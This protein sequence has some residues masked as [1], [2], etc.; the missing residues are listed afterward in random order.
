MIR[1]ILTIIGIAAMALVVA[2]M[3]VEA[4]TMRV[5][6]YPTDGA[7][8]PALQ[9]ALD[10]AVGTANTK[11]A[12]FQEQQDLA[13]GFAN[14]NGFSA[15]SG[16]FQGF[17]NYNIFSA[18]VGIM[19]GF[20]APT[21]DRSYYSP[22]NVES[23]IRDDGD[24]YAGFAA[25][26]SVNVG[27]HARFI[28][29]GL[30]LNVKYGHVELGDEQDLFKYKNTVYG[31]GINYGLLMPRTIVP[32]L[33]RWNGISFGTGI[34]YQKNEITYQVELDS[35]THN[36][37]GSI[38]MILDP[39]V[40]FRFDIATY[41]IPLEIVTSFRLLWLLNVSI[42]GGI[43]V[44]YGS[45]DLNIVS[46]GTVDVTGTTLTQQGIVAVDGTTSDVSPSRYR[47]KIMGALG[48]NILMV[49]IEV[50]VVYYPEAG[51]AVGLTIGVVF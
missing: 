7:N 41:T 29:T 45:S 43:D 27:I 47:T 22:D 9:L 37:G 5:V 28:A 23:D 2:S 50:P 19:A 3:S 1:K 14:A 8:D 17:Q 11:L 15:H 39:T 25:G 30:Y 20:Q 26:A 35:I 24:M 40:N 18:S 13:K 42:G 33:L 12:V 48:F 51:A 31:L 10:T 46:V 16:S 49:K 21:L 34:I 38:D 44:L 6:Q 4:A 36:V 32:V